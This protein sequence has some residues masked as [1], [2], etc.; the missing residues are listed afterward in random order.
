MLAE[1]WKS[2]SSLKSPSLTISNTSPAKPPT[3]PP[4]KTAKPSSSTP[5]LEK[6]KALLE[7]NAKL[8]VKWTTNPTIQTKKFVPFDSCD[9]F[10]ARYHKITQLVYWKLHEVS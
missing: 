8:L 4:I 2:I 10:I 9:P 5:F 7:L 1:M 6:E 3:L